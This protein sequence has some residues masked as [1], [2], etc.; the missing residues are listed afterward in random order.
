MDTLKAF[1]DKLEAE[2]KE[3]ETEEVV[4]GTNRKKVT[5]FCT[6]PDVMYKT[7]V[8][9]YALAS[10]ITYF[11]GISV[12]M[13]SNQRLDIKQRGFK[14]FAIVYVDYKTNSLLDETCIEKRINKY[15]RS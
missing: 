5:K 6:D 10:S 8:K 4:R 1:L 15:I 2:S 11:N 9:W 3:K 7:I 14:Q 13:N 12:W